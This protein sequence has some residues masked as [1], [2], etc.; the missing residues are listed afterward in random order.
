MF[1]TVN[2]R[3][4]VKL[5]KAAFMIAMPV[6]NRNVAEGVSGTRTN[7]NALRYASS[8]QRVGMGSEFGINKPGFGIARE[9]TLQFRG[10]EIGII[11]RT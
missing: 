10:A 7:A 3:F 4:R 2:G 9:V 11:G 8:R 6:V 1:Q 5:M